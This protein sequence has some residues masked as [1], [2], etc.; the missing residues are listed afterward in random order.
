MMRA[1]QRKSVSMAVL[2]SV[3]V[4]TAGCAAPKNRLYS[5]DPLPSEKIA[6][7]IAPSTTTLLFGTQAVVHAIDGKRIEASEWDRSAHAELLPGRH[8]LSVGMFQT[9]HYGLFWTTKTSVRDRVLELQAEAGHTYELR[10]KWSTQGGDD[11]W[12]PEVIDA[13]T[14]PVPPPQAAPAH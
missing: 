2:C 9:R 14:S 5:G 1:I 7:V 4:I 13:A 3:A 12:D 10:I 8:V 6:V 11:R